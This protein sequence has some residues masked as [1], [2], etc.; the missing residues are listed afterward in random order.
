MAA[1]LRIVAAACVLALGVGISGYGSALA[2]VPG[3][4]QNQYGA[5]GAPPSVRPGEARTAGPVANTGPLPGLTGQAQTYRLG[6]GD[7]IRVTVFGEPDLT[8]EFEI[9]SEGNISFPLV[10]EVPTRGLSPRQLEAE[11]VRLLKDGFLVNPRVNVEVSSYRPFFILGEVSRPGSYPYVASMTVVTA[12]AI[13]GGYTARANKRSMTIVRI[14]D[15]NRREIEASP[16]TPLL[17]EDI[18]TIRERFF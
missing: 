10:G 12:V 5:P 14:I 6:F 9:N 18:V 15:Q 8:G 11:L 2:Q 3:Y 13:A 16:E 4:Q 1:I 7:R 17:P